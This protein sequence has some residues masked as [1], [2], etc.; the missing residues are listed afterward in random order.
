M[1]RLL[2]PLLLSALVFGCDKHNDDYK[3]N[4]PGEN[5]TSKPEDPEDKLPFGYTLEDLNWAMAEI[6]AGGSANPGY[7]NVTRFIQGYMTVANVD[8][9]SGTLLSDGYRLNLTFD[10]QTLRGGVD[11]DSSCDDGFNEVAD[12]YGDT[13]GQYDAVRAVF[14]DNPVI[15]ALNNIKFDVYIVG[16]DYDGYTEGSLLNDIVTYNYSER[17]YHRA[18]GVGPWTET[19]MVDTKTNLAEYDNINKTMLSANGNALIL[20]LPAQ[21]GTYSFRMVATSGDNILCD[22][23]IENIELP[24][25]KE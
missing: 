11:S 21:A 18:I 12:G 25:R 10:G 13:Y 7:R 24:A 14:I 19:K 23:T 16:G 4:I 8:I 1:K 2:I 15:V 22:K 9:A 20:P 3:N 5:N 6:G 17:D